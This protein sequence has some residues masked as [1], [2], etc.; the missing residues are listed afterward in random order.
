[1]S[2]AITLLPL[3]AIRCGQGKLYLYIFIHLS[4]IVKENCRPELFP[5][6]LVQPTHTHTQLNSLQLD[7]NQQALHTS[8]TLPYTTYYSIIVNSLM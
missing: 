2:G 6:P 7:D 1:M 3:Y 5:S 4:F 8:T